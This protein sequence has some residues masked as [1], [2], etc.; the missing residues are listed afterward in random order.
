MDWL[1]AFLLIGGILLFKFLRSLF[2]GK[3]SH[4]HKHTGYHMY[5]EDDDDHDFEDYDAHDSYDGDGE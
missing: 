3:S 1:I 5:S 4:H 2:R